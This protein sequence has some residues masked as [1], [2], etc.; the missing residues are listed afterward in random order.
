MRAEH[1]R[2]VIHGDALLQ[3]GLARGGV[4]G[5]KVGPGPVMMGKN[6]VTMGSRA[7]IAKE[8]ERVEPTFEDKVLGLNYVKPQAAYSNSSSGW[9]SGGGWGGGGGGGGYDPKIYSRPAY[10][11]NNDKAASLYA[12]NPSYTRFD[13]LRPKVMTKGS[14]EAYRREDF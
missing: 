5:G 6:Q 1:D 13:Y 9:G 14:R 11:L 7:Y 12:K 8:P 4:R 3:P 10:S 2:R